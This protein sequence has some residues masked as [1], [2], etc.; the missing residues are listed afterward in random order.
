MRVLITS[1]STFFTPPLIQGFGARGVEV[2]AADSRWLSVGKAARHVARR[3]RL[4]VFARDPGGYLQALVKEVSTL[5]Y[6]FVLPAY[7]ES[8]LL[9]EYRHLLEPYTR[10]F[11]PTFETMWQVHDKRN[12]Y[13]LCQELR[14]PAPPTVVPQSRIALKQQVAA[15]RFPVVVKLPAANNC[16]GRSYCEDIAELTER[17]NRQFE[18]E[19]RGGADPP[20]IQQKIDGDPVCTLMLCHAGRKLGE[21]IYRPLRTCPERGGTSAHRESIEHPQISALNE[22]LSMA[23]NWTGFLGTDFIVDQADGTP[24][25]HDAN[26]RPTPAVHLGCVAGVDWA[27]ILVRVIENRECT[28]VVARPGVRTRSILLDLGWLLEGCRPQKHWLSNVRARFAKYRQPD[29]NLDV[30]Y[31]LAAKGEWLC[32]LALTYQGITG[33]LKALI[34]RGEIMQTMLADVNYDR[35]AIEKFRRSA[36]G[37]AFELPAHEPP[38]SGRPVQIHA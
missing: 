9:A 35:A 31:E 12:L 25:L 27:G 32:A 20:F 24:Y 18:K 3:V 26:P 1:T 23:T 10:L 21:V 7:E 16:V 34:T 37:E 30:R 22:R 6:D 38:E 13:K 2:T 28:P 36:Q 8:L 14:I 4:P 5:S 33:A 29:W 19:V 15:L 11:L 17:F